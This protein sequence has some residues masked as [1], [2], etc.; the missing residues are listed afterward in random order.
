MHFEKLYSDYKVS[1]ANFQ[2]KY[3]YSHIK[4]YHTTIKIL[5]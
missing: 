1:E 5:V 4:Y 2:S 3:F